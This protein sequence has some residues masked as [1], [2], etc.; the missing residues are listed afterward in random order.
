LQ[1]QVQHCANAVEVPV[2]RL[3]TNIGAPGKIAD[4]DFTKW[5][6]REQVIK[7]RK[8]ILPGSGYAWIGHEFLT[9]ILFGFLHYGALAPQ[10]GGPYMEH[11]FHKLSRSK[12]TRKDNADLSKNSLEI[13]GRRR[14]SHACVW[15]AR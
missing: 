3:P 9:F 4:T 2:E 5:L 1:A 10:S 6:F 7:C 14:G 8:Q 11:V 13:D 15:L 12:P